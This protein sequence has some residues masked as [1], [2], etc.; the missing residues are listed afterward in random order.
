MFDRIT[1]L[2]HDCDYNTKRE[3]MEREIHL[4]DGKIKNEIFMRIL[5][6]RTIEIGEA[7][8]IHYTDCSQSLKE[9]RHDLKTLFYFDC[10]CQ[11]CVNELMA[12]V[13]L[14]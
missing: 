13:H 12:D 14:D 9:R 7:I 8:T 6:S 11:R 2:S 1:L 10:S 4:D 3:I 5:A